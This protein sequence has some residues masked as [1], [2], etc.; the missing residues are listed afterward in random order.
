MWLA[1]NDTRDQKP[2]IPLRFLH[3][4]GLIHKL[5]DHLIGQNREYGS[6]AHS[7]KSVLKSNCES[8]VST[9]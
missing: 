6:P 9:R 2:S 4:R 5:H 1:I 7:E 3:E 8:K